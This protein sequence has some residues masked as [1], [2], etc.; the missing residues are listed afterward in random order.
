[1]PLPTPD[2]PPEPGPT[3]TFCENP[4]LRDAWYAV[5]R[6]P[7]VTVH[8]VPVTLL[9]TKVVLYL[10]AS[11]E[12]VAAPDRCPHREAPLSK[13]YVK[14]GCLVCPYHGWT[15]GDGGTCVRV[16]SANDDVPRP[17]GS[18]PG[19]GASPQSQRQAPPPPQQRNVFER[20]FGG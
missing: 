15:F 9:G 20:M 14:D 4:A 13:G 17:P 7:D 16:P 11:G 10:S 2:A 5:A 8:P 3:S 1:M 12:I 18:I 19:A 6:V